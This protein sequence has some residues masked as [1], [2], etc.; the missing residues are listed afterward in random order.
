MKNTL[1]I[2]LV[3]AAILVLAV[4]TAPLWGGCGFNR[5]LCNSWCVVRHL[6]SDLRQVACKASCAA[7]EVSCL[8]K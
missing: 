3:V 5:Q 6:D 1:K 2:A 8:A 7:D 4:I